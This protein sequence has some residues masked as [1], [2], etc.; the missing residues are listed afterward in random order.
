M[1]GKT[2]FSAPVE[3]PDLP[4]IIAEYYARR[5]GGDLTRARPD[6]TLEV[7]ATYDRVNAELALF[8]KAC[9]KG[10]VKLTGS[11]LNRSK[12]YDK[13]QTIRCL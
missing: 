6:G 9:S 13:S 5:D 10:I 2:N 4:S 3:R 1:Q 11:F 12:P 7:I 8:D